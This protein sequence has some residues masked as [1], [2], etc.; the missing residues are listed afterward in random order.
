MGGIQTPKKSLNCKLFGRLLK[1]TKAVY[2]RDED[3]VHALEK[4]GYKGAEFFMDTSRFAYDRKTIEKD[5]PSDKKVALINLNKNGE[6]FYQNLLEEC[7]S[8]LEEGYQLAYVPVS[9]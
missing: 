4:L 6:R 1:H 9:K 3:S 5:S 2:A 8:L 7:K